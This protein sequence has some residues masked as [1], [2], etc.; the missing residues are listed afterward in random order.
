MAMVDAG[1]ID[2]G[3]FN[4][5][6]FDPATWAAG[7]YIDSKGYGK[8]YKSVMRDR[9]LPLLAKTIYAYFASFAGGGTTAFP[10]RTTIRNGWT[11]RHVTRHHRKTGGTCANPVF[12]RFYRNEKLCS[13]TL[14]Q[15]AR[16]TPKG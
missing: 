8:I 7:V 6:T 5:D 14:Y 11:K 15:A 3:S 1:L 9:N 2:G 16:Q 10:R 4:T 13:N 12:K